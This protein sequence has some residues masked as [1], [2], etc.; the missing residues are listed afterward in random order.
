[1]KKL[2]MIGKT[3][4]GKTTLCQKIHNQE[5][6]YKKTQSV[7][8]YN[9]AI[10]TPGEYI[11]NR[12]YYSA[13]IVTAADADVIG[14]V[15]DCTSEENY[16]PPAYAASF[17]KDVIGIITKVDAAEKLEDIERAKENLMCAGAHKIFK[18]SASKGEGIEEL[19]QYLMGDDEA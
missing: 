19:C 15:L 7:E 12:V 3:S 14:L 11:E 18:V 5:M 10:D 4:A 1:M 16:F 13:L 17:P 9:Y 2:M 8:L 6:M